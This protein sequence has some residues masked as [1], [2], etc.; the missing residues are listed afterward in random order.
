M[1]D[2]GCGT[3]N[4]LA[5]FEKRGVAILGV[6]GDYVPRAQ[7]RIRQDCFLPMDLSTENYSAI[8]G[9]FDLAISIEV[10]E[11]LPETVADAFVEKLCTLS[12]IVLFSAAI[13]FQKGA[14]H[15]NCQWQGYWFDKFS[16][17]GFVGVDSLRK[18]IWYLD[19]IAPHYKQN[20]ILYI[21]KETPLHQ[22]L[23][24]DADFILDVV[25]PSVYLHK[26]EK[27]S[28][29]LR[30]RIKKILRALSDLSGLNPGR[31]AYS[32][33]LIKR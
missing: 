8:Q 22:Q 10:A 19:D 27:L 29:T 2:I 23:K 13:P 4:W 6:D 9:K 5:F 26:Q 1:V 21:R 18:Q 33:P 24:K 12:D 28:K 3:G 30:M 32:K 11:H 7:M 16:A 17:N 15:I 25:H 20:L 31:E 14:D